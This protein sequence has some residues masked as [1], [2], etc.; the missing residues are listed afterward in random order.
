MDFTALEKIQYGV[1]LI[2]S[3]FDGQKSAFAANSVMQVC[4]SPVKIAISVSKQNWTYG[5]IEK[6]GLFSISAVS[7]SAPFEFIGKFGFRSGKTFNKFENTEYKTFESGIPAVI[8]YAAAVFE[9]KITGKIDVG[10]HTVFIGE[11]L[12]MEKLSEE[13]T[14]TYEYYH[15]IKGG[16]T[17]K[18]APTYRN[19]VES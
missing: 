8:Q 14:M 1:Y 6:A 13:T 18:N 11:V 4:A 12:N 15:K 7:Q 3:A 17:A 9:L 5:L 10:S 2:A 19:K 16:L